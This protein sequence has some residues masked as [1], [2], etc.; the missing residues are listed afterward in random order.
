LFGEGRAAGEQPGEASPLTESANWVAPISNPVEAM[1]FADAT[2]AAPLRPFL[3]LG[4]EDP[5]VNSSAGRSLPTATVVASNATAVS[6]QQVSLDSRSATET[7]PPLTRRFTSA[8]EM[9]F[10][11]V[12]EP[13]ELT[14][15][16][17]PVPAAG[18]GTAEQGDTMKQG[19]DQKQFAEPGVQTLPLE[20]AAAAPVRRG[21]ARS[22]PEDGGL[23]EASVDTTSIFGSLLPLPTA[24]YLGLDGFG[25]LPTLNAASAVSVPELTQAGML[26]HV[27]ELRYSGATELAVVLQ[28][29]ADTQLALRLTFNSNGEVSVQA[30]CEQGDAQ[31][32]AANWGDIRDAL[33]QQGV[34]LGALE[35][36]PELKPENL[37]PRTGNG[38]PSPD[39]QPSSQ[40]HGQPWPETLD[41]L[42]LVGSQTEAPS[43]RSTQRLP[44]GRGRSW[45]SWA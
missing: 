28:P 38:G 23:M 6:S 22:V 44:V 5:P 19:T 36:A 14:L 34:R 30:R 4:L 18:T 31:A 29:D 3:P 11:T 15:M 39:G 13:E 9:M 40:R 27:T 7:R 26:R 20:L 12:A 17:A 32:L 24:G 43:R 41:D 37:T 35:L 8:A 1:E 25:D 10:T 42:P 16:V 45:E 21:G 2:A 33:A